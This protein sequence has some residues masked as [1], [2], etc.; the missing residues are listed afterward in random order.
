MRKFKACENSVVEHYGHDAATDERILEDEDMTLFDM[1]V[2]Y[3]LY[4][5]K[6]TCSFSMNGNFTSDQHFLYNVVLD[7]HNVVKLCLIQE[8]VVKRPSVNITP[9]GLGHF[10]G[11]Y[12]HDP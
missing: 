6:I 9:H 11:I 12:S 7:A 10:L 8:G 4:V 2:E 3:N 1:G 5:S